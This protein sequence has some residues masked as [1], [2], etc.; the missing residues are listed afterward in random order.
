M[1][2]NSFRRL[3]EF[4]QK[5]SALWSFLQVL[6]LELVFVFFCLQSNVTYCLRILSSGDLTFSALGESQTIKKAV[7]CEIYSIAQTALEKTSGMQKEEYLGDG[8]EV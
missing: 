1:P 2:G 6:A 3:G 4:F 5:S 8:C 7:K